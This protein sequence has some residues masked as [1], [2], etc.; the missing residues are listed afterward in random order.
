MV[1][2]MSKDLIQKFNFGAPSK[3]PTFK[4]SFQRDQVFI[5]GR[6]CKYARG[7]PQTPWAPDKET[8]KM[9]GNSVSEKISKPL[10]EYFRADTTR[11]NSSGREDI[12]VRML[13]TGRPFAVCLVNARRWAEMY[14]N[15]RRSEVLQ[16]LKEKINRENKE[17]EIIG[18]LKLA[19]LEQMKELNIGQ[20]AKKKTYTA[21]CYSY[22]PIN[23]E[24]AKKVEEA[25]PFDIKQ[26]TPVRVL[27]RRPLMERI[28]TIHAARVDLIDDHYF[29]LHLETQAG[30]YVKEFV[31]GDFGRTRPSV[32][33]L[34]GFE[35][36]DGMSIL[37]LDVTGVDLVWPLTSSKIG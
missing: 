5:A 22:F 23:S 14:K 12:D 20:D 31:N 32:A 21:L 24:M 15:E 29:L 35:L 37:E 17:I 7:L 26:W 3:M 19:T 16:L 27:I 2:V 13:G 36:N 33:N 18:D 6:Y 10:L 11:F 8:P 30:T 1:E 34:M 25:V 9:I 4:V 28:R